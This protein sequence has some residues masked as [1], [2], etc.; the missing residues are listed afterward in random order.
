MPSRAP[1]PATDARSAVDARPSALARCALPAALL[2]CAL[3]CAAALWSARGVPRGVVRHALPMALLACTALGAGLGLLTAVRA[4][5]RQ[6]AS[7]PGLRWLFV[8]LVAGWGAQLAWL[9]F[10]RAPW[11]ALAQA[12]AFGLYALALLVVQAREPRAPSRVI[13]ALEFA[14]FSAATALV[15]GELALRAAGAFSNSPL[16]DTH[17]MDRRDW[18]ESHRREPGS[19]HLGFPID[20]RGNYDEELR[21]RAP[22]ERLIAVVGDSFSLGVVPHAHHYTTLAERLLGN[23]QIYNIGVPSTDPPEYLYM[24]RDDALPLRPDAIVVSLF[25]GNDFSAPAAGERRPGLLKLVLDRREAL[26]VQLPRRVLALRAERARQRNSVR[27]QGQIPVGDT[28]AVQGDPLFTRRVEGAELAERM[29]WLDDV[30]LEPPTFSPEKYLELERARAEQI[31][32][33]RAHPGAALEQSID[34]LVEAAAG[35]PI[36]FLLI[37]DE[38]QVEDALWSS[39]EQASQLELERELPQR[40]IRGFL[41]RR[42]LPYVDLLPRL[43]AVEPNASGARRVYHLR[44]THFNARGNRIAARGLFDL[45]QAIDAAPPAA[46]RAA[47]E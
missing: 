13:R 11:S 26:V 46:Q 33:V 29:P 40:Q 18:I 17:G 21:A 41:E 39:I 42:G 30:R 34:L 31:C 19:F 32:A 16:L 24:L 4:W 12:S 43:L 15:L 22:G 44:D 23:A 14:L 3:A 37:P 2:V 8:A 47:R 7:A 9:P 1:G 35:T 10:Y 36:G 28:R 27:V 20:S 45:V 25:F 38:A 5:R 6:R